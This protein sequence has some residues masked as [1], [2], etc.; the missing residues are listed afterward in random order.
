MGNGTVTGERYTAG[1]TLTFSCD[2]GYK[3][4][5]YVPTFSMLWT[6]PIPIFWLRLSC[7]DNTQNVLIAA[8]LKCGPWP[9]GI[10]TFSCDTY[11]SRY[12]EITCNTNEKWSADTPS[13]NGKP[14]SHS[15]HFSL[16]PSFTS[17]FPP[18][19]LL[20]VFVLRCSNCNGKR[21]R[22]AP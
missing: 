22:N 15:P 10:V 4:S 5:G 20:W 12:E 21:I 3:L 8:L 9:F 17:F 18:L 16:L 13:C 1:S 7:Y 2:E 14:S 11:F 6:P 19:P